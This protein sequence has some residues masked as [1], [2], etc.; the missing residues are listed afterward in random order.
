[1]ISVLV[2]DDLKIIHEGLQ[3]M[4]AMDEDIKIVGFAEN[5]KQ[6]ISKI[7]NSDRHPDIV[8][9]DI[10]MPVM[11]G[12]ETTKEISRLFP[13]IKTI[14]LSGFEDDPLI[15]KAIAAGAKGYLLK[16]AISQDLASAVRSVHRGASHFAPGIVDRLAKNFQSLPSISS[17]VLPQQICTIDASLNPEQ[18]K[19]IKK[20]TEK[21]K[22][23]LQKPL[24]Q[25]GD[26]LTIIIS[27]IVLSRTNGMGHH[28]A[29]AGLFF[30]MLSL[31]A[32]P[33]K[34]WWSWPLQHRRAIGIFAFA[35]AVAH[36]FYATFQVLD[37]DLSKMLALSPRSKLGVIIGIIS[38]L[39]MTPAAITSFQFFQRKLG[40]RWRQIHLLTVPALALAVIHTILVGPHYLR[41]FN[42][43]T[44]DYVR[45]LV[46]ILSGTLVL[47]MRRKIFWS[48]LGLNNSGKKAVAKNQ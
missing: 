18:P 20:R 45:T 11:D 4:F 38:L 15:L 48:T 28:L 19:L 9:V 44:I 21:A 2:V 27:V 14:V 13:E 32:R 3:A 29:H 26:W 34:A 25:Y 31:V 10:V 35:A 1:M 39:A 37:L 30:L 16:N 7:Q 17:K 24:F 6:A 40:K 5:G 8:L 46:A 33:I 22:P 47:L 36:A 41:T 42:I 43:N 12:I 23:K